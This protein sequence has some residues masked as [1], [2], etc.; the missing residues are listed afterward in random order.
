MIILGAVDVDYRK[1]LHS[2]Q[3]VTAVKGMRRANT[4]RSGAFKASIRS[5]H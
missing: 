5:G 3:L 4:P 1:P 2:E